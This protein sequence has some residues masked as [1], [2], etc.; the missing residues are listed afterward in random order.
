MW[1]LATKYNNNT[2][3]VAK[4]FA[5]AGHADPAKKQRTT[6]LSRGTTIKMRGAV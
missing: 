3:L 1:E 6:F 4:G 2:G 5:F